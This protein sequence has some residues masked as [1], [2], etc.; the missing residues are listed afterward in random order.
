MLAAA[1]RL[2]AASVNPRFN[3]VTPALVGQGHRGGFKLLVWT[4]DKADEMD[5]MIALGVDGIMTNYPARLA[6]R[7][8]AGAAR[9]PT[10]QR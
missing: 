2:G 7:L 5:R 1:A 10:S 9:Q 3:L 6:A 8:N 4:V